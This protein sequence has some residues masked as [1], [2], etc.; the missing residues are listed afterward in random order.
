[1]PGHAEVLTYPLCA[2]A[3]GS[4]DLPIMCLG[5]RE[6]LPIHY[7]PG[8]EEVL[9]YP[10]CAWACGSVELPLCAWACGSVDLSIMCL[11]MC[12]WDNYSG[13]KHHFHKFFSHMAVRGVTAC[14]PK[15][16]CIQLGGKFVFLR[17]YLMLYN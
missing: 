7:V 8:H 17:T 13:F 5:M 14:T 2:W 6:C 15:R 1:M 9:T 11:G 3:C 12:V 16:M 10:L 4:V